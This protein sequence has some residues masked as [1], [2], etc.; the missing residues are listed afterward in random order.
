MRNR[1]KSWLVVVGLGLGVGNSGASPG[2]SEGTFH[3]FATDGSPGAM[4]AIPPLRNAIE[5]ERTPLDGPDSAVLIAGVSGTEPEIVS[6]Y[7]VYRDD[8]VQPLTVGRV[9][10]SSSAPRSLLALGHDFLAW[11]STGDVVL[12]RRVAP[13]FR[14]ARMG[15][16]I[17]SGDL[18]RAVA[19]RDPA[20]PSTFHALFYSGSG[21]AA[22]VARVNRPN[23]I[24]EYFDLPLAGTLADLRVSIGPSRG[25]GYPDLLVTSPS[26]G[27]LAVVPGSPAPQRA[28]ATLYPTGAVGSKHGRVADVDGDGDLDVLTVNTAGTVSLFLQTVAGY[29]L[30][31]PLLVG[32]ELHD[33]AA[34]SVSGELVAMHGSSG[35]SRVLFEV[36]SNRLRLDRPNFGDGSLTLRLRDP[37]TGRPALETALR[38]VHCGAEP[39]I[40][41]ELAS[42]T[43]LTMGVDAGEERC[44]LRALR[45]LHT[46][47]ERVEPNWVIRG[48]A[49]RA[50]AGPEPELG[51]VKT[52]LHVSSS[53]RARTTVA[54]IDSG[55]E[56]T[57]RTWSNPR[58]S[59]NGLDDDGNGYI[60]DI[61]GVDFVGGDWVGPLFRSGPHALVDSVPGGH[62]TAVAAAADYIADGIEVMS[63]R[64]LD[65]NNQTTA[66]EL[67][68]AITYAADNGA[69]VINLSLAGSDES[70]LVRDALRYAW[71]RGVAVIAAAGNDGSS[72]S[73][74]YPALFPEALAIGAYG[75]PMPGFPISP[76]ACSN[77]GHGA[78]LLAP[79]VDVCIAGR[80]DT[81]TSIAT[82]LAT[83]VVAAL[84]DRA[85]LCP[86][87]VR[88]VLGRSAYQLNGIG[89]DPRTGFGAVNGI[90]ALALA[91]QIVPI[92]EPLSTEVAKPSETLFGA[93]QADASFGGV[94]QYHELMKD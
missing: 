54:I 10:I 79:G 12:Y 32:S 50:A 63:L 93:V 27:Q 47:V 3:R 24:A 59:R 31:G 53:L 25:S 19:W 28:A 94:I 26:S 67:A 34:T 46:I 62:G 56:G 61:D 5:V 7:V 77:S 57:V 82:A 22:Y 4:L 37:L 16:R 11:Q 9:S 17:V 35:Q 42:L 91:E 2:P 43:V 90:D 81:G 80:C 55:V 33:I 72:R 41:Q 66:L 20:V 64:V 8:Y 88:D 87:D 70:E 83:G 44:A 23:P 21:R 29:E 84:L 75:Q 49:I 89:W 73:V 48:N 58:E 18:T 52:A 39:V 1:T 14:S 68:L 45:D 65:E 30:A 60:D 85:E 38:D 86:S 51:W 76:W 78:G 36:G 6:A 40:R 13:G 15:R 71:E 74:A 92:C 69:A